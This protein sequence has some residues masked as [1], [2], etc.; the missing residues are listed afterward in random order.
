MY[1]YIYIY[2]YIYRKLITGIVNK[3]FFE[4]NKAE[5]I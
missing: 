2:I 5:W 1:I 3:N 4:Q